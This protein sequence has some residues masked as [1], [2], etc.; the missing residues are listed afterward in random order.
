MK[1][2]AKGTDHPVYTKLLTAKYLELLKGKVSPVMKHQHF[3]GE[4]KQGSIT[5]K[6]RQ[7][8]ECLHL[9]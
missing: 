9:E 2:S 4:L 8:E 7:K 5:L 6:E 3:N 1:F